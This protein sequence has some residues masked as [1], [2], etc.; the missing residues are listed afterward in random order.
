MN[1][2]TIRLAEAEKI[3]EWV[4]G[5]RFGT[6]EV[7]D[8]TAAIGEDSLGNEAM[9]FMLYLAERPPGVTSWPLEDW[10]ELRRQTHDKARSSGIDLL[11]Y[12]RVNSIA[13]RPLRETG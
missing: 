3:I 4:R 13:S 9:Y 12:F 1:L 11:C 5:R 8:A 10:S 7:V 2:D 6:I